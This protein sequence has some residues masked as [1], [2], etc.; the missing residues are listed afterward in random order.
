LL[1]KPPPRDALA[2][3]SVSNVEILIP[4]YLEPSE[5]TLSKFFFI[6]LK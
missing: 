1:N 6:A 2:C 5:I 4:T 3:D